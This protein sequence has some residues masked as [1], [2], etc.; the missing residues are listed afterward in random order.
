[1]IDI[2]S[3][4]IDSFGDI[5]VHT[6]RLHRQEIIRIHR[7]VAVLQGHIE[8]SKQRRQH[9]LDLQQGQIHPHAIAFAQTEG[10]EEALQERVLG[11]SLVPTV[12]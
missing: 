9:D 7:F 4:L 11:V 1:M 5:N 6:N 12:G 8:R 2:K 10:H 3:E